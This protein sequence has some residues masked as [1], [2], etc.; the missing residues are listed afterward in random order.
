[1][2]GRGEP[3][4]LLIPNHLLLLPLTCVSK[5]EIKP[6][7]ELL[8]VIE[9]LAQ[10]SHIRQLYQREVA[11]YWEH[12]DTQKSIIN[13]HAVS[14]NKIDGNLCHHKTNYVKLCVVLIM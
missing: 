8:G 7:K 10:G 13:A 1:M 5:L 11:F 12:E 9:T 3:R 2:R 14:T 6:G 4:E